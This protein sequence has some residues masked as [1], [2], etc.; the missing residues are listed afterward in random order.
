MQPRL[1]LKSVL[2]LIAGLLAAP[3]LALADDDLELA[4]NNHCRECHSALKG[5][6]R[7]GPTLYGVVG[8]K[9]ASVPTYG[10][11]SPALMDSGIT[12]TEDM[13]DQWIANPSAVASGNN[14][15]PPYPGVADPA[16][17]AKIIA[18]LKA[19]TNMPPPG[20]KPVGAPAPDKLGP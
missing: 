1:I 4:F 17:R 14:M 12:W 3:T 5:D 6:N 20:A 15:Q 11:Y 13:L 19:D 10:N 18:Y 7:L 16:E 8:R 2:P 9:A